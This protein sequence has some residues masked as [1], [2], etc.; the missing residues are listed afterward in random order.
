[1]NFTVKIPL[2]GGE[3]MHSEWLPG[4]QAKFS[5]EPTL[6]LLLKVLYMVASLGDIPLYIQIIRTE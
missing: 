3:G 6:T 5:P 1:M 4:L 2:G